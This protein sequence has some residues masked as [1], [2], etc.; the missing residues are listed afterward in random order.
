MEGLLTLL[1]D[2]DRGCLAAERHFGG[3]DDLRKPDVAIQEQGVEAV[4]SPQKFDGNH[5]DFWS[6]DHLM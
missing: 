2:N 4:L 5:C 3:T 1:K 6:L